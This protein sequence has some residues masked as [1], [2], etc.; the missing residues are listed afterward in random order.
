MS[1]PLE[2]SPISNKHQTIHYNAYSRPSYS[3]VRKY[4]QNK[5]L[6]LFVR[7]ISCYTRDQEWNA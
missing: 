4:F 5:I 7:P 6:E 3:R 2:L 1:L